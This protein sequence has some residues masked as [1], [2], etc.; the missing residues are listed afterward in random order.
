MCR[1]G[2]VKIRRLVLMEFCRKG[3]FLHLFR[4]PVTLIFDL[5]TTKSIVSCSCPVNYLR[6][7]AGTV[8]SRKKWRH[9][10]FQDADLSHLRFYGSNNSKFTAIGPLKSKMAEIRRLGRIP[11]HVIPQTPATLQGAATWWIHCHDSRATCHIA[12][13]SHLAKSMSW[14][15]LIAGCNK[16]RAIGSLKSKMA[17]IWRLENRHDVIFLLR[18]VRFG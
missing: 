13:C 4:S 14:S 1:T 5:M 18:V 7:F 6:Q 12:G 11:W 10:D 2:L 15:C 3:F 8:L 16:F 17:E 9:V